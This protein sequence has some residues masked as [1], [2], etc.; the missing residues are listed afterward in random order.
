MEFLQRKTFFF[1]FFLHFQILS[2][3]TKLKGNCNLSLG[4][5]FWQENQM[6][7]DI[8]FAKKSCELFSLT[9]LTFLKFFLH[10]QI[11]SH[12]TKLNGN[13]NLSLGIYFWQKNQMLKDIFLK[14]ILWALFTHHTYFC[15][16]K[17]ATYNI[18]I[19][20]SQAIYY[21]SL[22]FWTFW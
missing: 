3:K 17:K 1:Y 7:K 13:C 20:I 2:H 15:D 22:K 6:L 18:K 4:I 11:L 9:I 10:F 19:K 5:Y 21:R 8:L 14:K 12:K 16:F